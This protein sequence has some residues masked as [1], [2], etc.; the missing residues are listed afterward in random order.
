MSYHSLANLSPVNMIKKT[1]LFAALLLITS[2]SLMAQVTFAPKIGLSYST[3]K[4][5]FNNAKYMPGAFFGGMFNL[6][7]HEFYSF[8]TG[9]FLSGKG[10]TLRY[11]QTDDDQMLISY[12]ELPFNSLLTIPAGSGAMQLFA[13]PYLGFALGGRY[14]YLEDENN[15]IEKLQIG[16]S[17]SDEI[18]PFDAGFSIGAGFLFEGFEVQGAYRRLLKNISNSTVDKLYNNVI[19]ISMAYFFDLNPNER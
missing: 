6:K 10:T 7:V 3:F 1:F 2:F 9:M 5:D 8:Q 16:T 19:T 13:G 4:G 15:I 17:G 18:K 11:S 14:K 12:L